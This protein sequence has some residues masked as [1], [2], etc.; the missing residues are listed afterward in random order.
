MEV[1]IHPGS[2][3]SYRGKNCPEWAV[4]QGDKVIITAHIMTLNMMKE[5]F[6]VCWRSI[7]SL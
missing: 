4:L 7:E 5:M 3:P 2:L 1:N 6:L